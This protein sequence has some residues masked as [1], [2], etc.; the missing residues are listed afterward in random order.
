LARRQDTRSLALRAKLLFGRFPQ[1]KRTNG[2]KSDDDTFSGCTRAK[3]GALPIEAHN[4]KVSIIEKFF[5]T[6]WSC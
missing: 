5:G 6:S 2:E 3:F 1:V 4:T